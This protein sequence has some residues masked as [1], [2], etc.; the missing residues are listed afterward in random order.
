MRGNSRFSVQHGER[1][2]RR[3]AVHRERRMQHFVRRDPDGRRDI[4]VGGLQEGLVLHARA[5]RLEKYRRTTVMTGD[6]GAAGQ[7]LLQAN[8]VVIDQS[9]RH[10]A[11]TRRHRRADAL[12]PERGEAGIAHRDEHGEQPRRVRHQ[13]GPVL[14]VEIGVFLISGATRPLRSPSAA[15]TESSVVIPAPLSTLASD[16]QS[17]PNLSFVASAASCGISARIAA[18][19]SAKT[20]RLRRHSSR[21]RAR[22]P[23]ARRERR[24]A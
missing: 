10:L 17:N 16:G 19:S 22:R 20:R 4:V 1:G 5:V 8:D 2:S 18:G 24:S 21:G 11:D 3:R 12:A 7:L 9:A 23:T 15:I 14:L 13:P 6:E